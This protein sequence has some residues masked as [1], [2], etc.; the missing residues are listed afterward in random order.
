MTYQRPGGFSGIGHGLVALLLLVA[1]GNVAPAGAEPIRLETSR[2][3]L[4]PSEP[5]QSRVGRLTYLGGLVI[6]SKDARFGGY[7]GLTL[8]DHDTRMLAISDAGHWLAARL[9]HDAEGRLTGLADGEIEPLLDAAGR[10]VMDKMESDAESVRQDLDG[11]FLVSFE[12][13]HR[14]LRYQADASGLPIRSRGAMIPTP[15]DLARRVPLNEGI[16]A[17]TPLRDGRL[18]LLS[19]G[20]RTANNDLL[21]WIRQQGVWWELAY[22]QT[23][24]FVPTDATLLPDGNVLVLERR[25]SWIGGLGARLTQLSSA[26]VAPNARLV[27][28]LIADFSAPLSVDN[29]EGLAVASRNGE[30]LVYILSD[31]NQNP[32][33]RTLLMLFR[34]DP[35]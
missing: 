14:I 10:P 19:E 5:S 8:V 7:S 30:T 6:D 35:R 28:E 20:G 31:D 24:Q 12:H 13:H 17:F 21:G 1:A 29:M 4:N 11:S 25:F 34:L 2:L 22:R 3:L 27:S 16:E 33:Q 26:T 9:V 18:L 23:A 15:T 32:L